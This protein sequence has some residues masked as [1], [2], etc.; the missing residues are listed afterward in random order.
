MD[1]QRANR[2]VH[3]RADI[4]RRQQLLDAPHVAS[5]QQ[6]DRRTRAG[7]ECAQDV[8]ILDG[9]DLTGHLVIP[10]TGGMQN[11]QTLTKQ[12]VRLREGKQVMRLVFDGDPRVP[13]ADVGNLNW[14]RITPSSPDDAATGNR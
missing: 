5:D 8:G 2:G 9:E 1:G 6:R 10:N 11:W 12:R 7:Q 13:G 14:I 4:Q 3:A